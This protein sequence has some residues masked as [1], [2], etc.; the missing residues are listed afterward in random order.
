ML[1]SGS[2][3]A[4]V[5]LSSDHVCGMASPWTLASGGLNA[6]SVVEMNGYTAKTAKAMRRM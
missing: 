1:A 3:Q 6:T 2:V 5:K 4:V